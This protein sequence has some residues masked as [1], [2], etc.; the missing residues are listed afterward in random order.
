MTNVYDLTIM[1]SMDIGHHE[2]P[3]TPGTPEEE[4]RV[5]QKRQNGGGL[6]TEKDRLRLLDLTNQ[7]ESQKNQITPAQKEALHKQGTEAELTQ[8]DRKLVQE[9]NGLR[10][11]Q[12]G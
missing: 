1:L 2:L 11:P 7:Q 9:V 10:E 5:L 8:E 12:K 6:W 4:L 3:Q